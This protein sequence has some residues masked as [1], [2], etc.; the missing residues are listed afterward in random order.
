M[1]SRFAVDRW[2]SAAGLFLWNGLHGIL[3][4]S[5]SVGIQMWANQFADLSADR[6]VINDSKT[7]SGR[8][9]IGSLRGVLIHDAVQRVLA[10]RGQE[11]V[12]RYGVDDCDPLDRLP[13]DAPDELRKC[14]GMPLYKV[15]APPDSKH[16][17]FAEHHISDFL[18]VFEKLDVRYEPYR[19]SE[20]YRRGDFDQ[21]IRDVLE[22]LD[23]VR[24]VYDSFGSSPRPPDWHPLQ[25]ICERCG[26]I[27]TTVVNAFDGD[28]V[29]YRCEPQHQTWAQGCGH[30][31]RVS[32]FGGNGKLPWKLEWMAK[33]RVFGVHIEGAG[34]DHFSKGGSHD[35]ATGCLRALYD[36]PPPQK[37]PYE[38]FLVQGA[39]MSSS[40]GVG[41][42]AFEMAW[43]LPPEILRF[44]MVRTPPKRTLNF[45]TSMDFMA[46]LFNDYDRLAVKVDTG[47]ADENQQTLYSLTSVGG[48]AGASHP[49]DFKLVAALLKMEHLDIWSELGKLYNLGNSNSEHDMNLIGSLENRISCADYWLDH[50]AGENGRLG[51]QEGLQPLAM[52]LSQVQLGFLDLL[53]KKLDLYKAQPVMI[54]STIPEFIQE[55]TNTNPMYLEE[56]DSNIYQQ[57]IF[58]VARLTPIASTAAFE[59]IYM[60]FLNQR[61]GPK[62]GALLWALRDNPVDIMNQNIDLACDE[63]F[64]NE[65]FWQESAMSIEKFE[66][67]LLHQQ[68]SIREAEY[69][70]YPQEENGIFFYDIQLYLQDDKI[71]IKRVICQT[72]DERN[73]LSEITQ[74]ILKEKAQE[75]DQESA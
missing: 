66:E 70:F 14:M 5:G 67:E 43:F 71:L 73:Q 25:V 69:R 27:G 2:W 60:L 22:N 36:Q 41:E 3:L 54:M 6:L 49:A 7:P 30:S 57:A 39:K 26:K 74:T 44:L 46:R 4:P 50:F 18:D 1:R 13:D 65:L 17:N 31:A 23:R 75:R 20:I 52:E 63:Y 53:G 38:F 58:D 42:S 40:K 47:E 11:V 33:W 56:G 59:A 10:A 9:H 28:D 55:N 12:F 8:V 16:A 61:E 51:V 62:A 29:S 48:S 15:P 37:I 19:M 24:V 34:K 32:P 45:N 35:V 72:L 68:E 64:N 21:V